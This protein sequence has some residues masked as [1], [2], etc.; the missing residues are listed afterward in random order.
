MALNVRPATTEEAVAIITHDTVRPSFEYDGADLSLWL[1][2]PY[3]I[4][5][6][7]ELDGKVLTVN[8]AKPKAPSSNRGDG[9]FNRGGFNKGGGGYNRGGGNDRGGRQGGSRY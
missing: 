2:K 3:S 7:A 1:P 9:G 6:A 4:T 8:V 5:L